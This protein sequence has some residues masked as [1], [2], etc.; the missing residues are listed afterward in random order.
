MKAT[1]KVAAVATGLAMAT[2]MLSLAPIAHAACSVGTV[3]LTVGSTGAAVT[4]LQQTLIG[5]GY[6]IPA[7]ATGYF[8]M[9]TKAAVAAWQAAV[10]ISP[11]AGYF[12]PISRAALGGSG[13][14]S[15]G[16]T[17]S[18]PGCAAG[19]MYS[20]TTGQACWTSS[21]V[22]GCAAGAMFSSTTGQACGSG[23]SMGGSLSGS[24]RLTNVSSFGDV[25]SDLKEGDPTTAVVGEEM[26]ATGG[27][28]AI[29]RVDVT[30]DLSASTGSV[31]LDRYVSDV[32]V[33]L[34][35]TKLAT[36][37]ASAG[38]KTSGSRIWTLRFSGLNGVIKSGTTGDL[39][40][41][42]T[43]LDSIG[44]NED[45][46]T[47]TASLL[48]DSIRAVGA[49]GISD[50]Y[51]STANN[52]TFTVSSATDGTLTVTEAGDDPK[53]SQIAVGSS[54][55]TGVK[56]LSFNMKAKNQDITVT[57]LKAGFGTSDNN[58][59]DVVSRV[60]LMKGSTV[61]STKTV[62]TGTYGTVTFTNIDQTI[63]KDDTVN[64]TIVADI[65]GD[66]SYSDGTTLMASTTAG[67][68]NGWDVSDADGNTVNPSAA[69][70]GNTMTLTATGVSVA[71][72]DFT[73][74]VTAGLA[75]GGDVGTYTMP[76]TVTAG[77]NDVFIGSVQTRALTP[78]GSATGVNYAT[79]TS[80][81]NVTSPTVVTSFSA[82][83][84]VTGDT[85]GAFKVL[86]GTSRT[87]T[88]TISATAVATGLFG[89]QITGIN[90]GPSSSLGSTYYTS[91][92][93][94]FKTNDVTLVKHP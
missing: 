28:V 62:G 93:D 2:S 54:T 50:T 43:P 32:S 89:F 9:Q 20:S 22:P 35:G 12:G 88:L 81:S 59:N 76:F 52:Q 29:Q 69:V 58:L 34:N 23:S 44:T 61:L 41:K 25:E 40:V 4:C 65:K 48:A 94:T 83:N 3:N 21:T 13:T 71:K 73:T 63:A 92:L 16:G 74:D 66:D 53:A 70:V 45:G 5:A 78:S 90:Y 85:G 10:G 39:V 27:D 11:A 14:V 57:D 86:A 31:N 67:T 87:F 18:V 6:S 72:G 55:T 77:D 68:N 7:G 17:S 60:M 38:D 37:D 26:D 64:Y 91:N 36:M 24:G 33:W 47:V 1:A 79:T 46:Q 51:V 49:D 19:A 84:T 15:T 42:V 82:G 8:G 30:F 56:L 75:G 80:S